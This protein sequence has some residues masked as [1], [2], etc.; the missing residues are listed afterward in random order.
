MMGDEA[1][2]RRASTESPNPEARG[3]KEFLAVYMQLPLTNHVGIVNQLSKL[4]CLIV[5]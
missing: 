2:R 3:P 1:D 5:N 4:L